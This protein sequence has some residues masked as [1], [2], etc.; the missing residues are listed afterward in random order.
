MPIYLTI[1]NIS[2]GSHI[3]NTTYV[4]LISFHREVYSMQL[5]GLKF[6]CDFSSGTLISSANKTDCPVVLSNNTL[7]S[8]LVNWL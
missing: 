5:Y 6:V 4:V 7:T 2:R 3:Y 8:K 1:S